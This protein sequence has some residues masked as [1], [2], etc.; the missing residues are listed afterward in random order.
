MGR[1]CLPGRVPGPGGGGRPHLPLGH[2]GE[3]Q[4]GGVWLPH[5]KW[6]L[7]G[8]SEAGVPTPEL[9]GPLLAQVS[10]QVGKGFPGRLS[11]SRPCG[12]QGGGSTLLPSHH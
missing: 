2:G 5:L 3:G 7:D 12:L 1:G 10:A 6:G 4:G 9:G 8:E 11:L